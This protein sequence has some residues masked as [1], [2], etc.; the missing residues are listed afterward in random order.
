MWSGATGLHGASPVPP[1]LYGNFPVV[2]I[3]RNCNGD[4]RLETHDLSSLR[5]VNLEYMHEMGRAQ[6]F[7]QDEFKPQGALFDYDAFL[8]VSSRTAERL[9]GSVQLRLPITQLAFISMV[10]ATSRPT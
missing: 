4:Y 1:W 9:A 7:V 2:F 10:G 3:D 5:D 8:N 6:N